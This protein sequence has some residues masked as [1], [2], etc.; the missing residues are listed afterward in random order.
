MVHAALTDVIRKRTEAPK[1]LVGEEAKGGCGFVGYGTRLPLTLELR[2]RIAVCI[3]TPIYQQ[4]L[5]P[6]Q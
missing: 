5:L 2:D 1:P 3:P 6:V 4:R